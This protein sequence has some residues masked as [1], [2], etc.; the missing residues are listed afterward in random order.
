MTFLW[1][2]LFRQFKYVSFFKEYSKDINCTQRLAKTVFNGFCRTR[3]F[4]D[5]PPILSCF[6]PNYE[7]YMLKIQVP[8]KLSCK[9]HVN[10]GYIMEISWKLFVTPVEWEKKK[11]FR[12]KWGF[13]YLSRLEIWRYSCVFSVKSKFQQFHGVTKIIA[14]CNSVSTH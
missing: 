14:V 7:L 3:L 10:H 6:L 11:E 1:I 2:L 8:Y 4:S 12:W 5:I 9:Y 13:M